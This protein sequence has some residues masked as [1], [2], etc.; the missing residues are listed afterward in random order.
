MDQVS[1]GDKHYWLNSNPFRLPTGQVALQYR[2]VAKYKKHTLKRF[3]KFLVEGD[4]SNFQSIY[5]HSGRRLTAETHQYDIFQ[6]PGNKEHYRSIFAGVLYFVD[7][8]YGLLNERSDFKTILN[9]CERICSRLSRIDKEEG[10]QVSR[11]IRQVMSESNR[12]YQGA[13]VCSLLGQFKILTPY[14][15]NIFTSMRPE[16][17]NQLLGALAHCKYDIIPQT[18][19]AYIKSIATDLFHASIEKGWLAFLSYFANLLEVKNLLRTAEKLPMTYPEENFNTLTV[20]LVGLLVSVKD[21]GDRITILDFVIDRCR[22]INCLW[23]LYGELSAYLPGITDVLADHF[24]QAFCQ[25]LVCPGRVDFLQHDVWEKTPHELRIVL[26]DSF[27]KALQSQIAKETIFS[28]GKLR[29]FKSY[30]SHKDICSSKHFVSFILN[31]TKNKSESVFLVLVEMLDCN[32]FF[33]T[34]RRLNFIDRSSI[35]KYLLRTKLRSHP[36]ENVVQVLKAA[37]TIVETYALQHDQELHLVLEKCAIEMLQNVSFEAIL[38]AYLHLEHSSQIVESCYL[39]LL[40]D[41]VKRKSMTSSG[42]ASIIKMLLSYLDVEELED[43]L[44]S[45]KFHG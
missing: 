3:I 23:Y 13:F 24:S 2:Y 35:C 38:S 41:A 33:L 36:R 21:D 37:K 28:A 1:S 27:V 40:R 44:P 6:V 16:I 43:D 34:W 32:E 45:M 7:M 15:C 11:W 26:V 18:S 8:L 17:A 39:S 42:K 10:I 14:H 22:S 25:L 20:Y 30:V 12:W 29:T 4:H 19:V 31:L 9:E 5:E